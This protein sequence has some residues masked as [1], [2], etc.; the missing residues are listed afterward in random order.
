MM[1]ARLSKQPIQYPL[2]CTS[3]KGAHVVFADQYGRKDSLTP[4]MS[5][6]VVLVVLECLSCIVTMPVQREAAHNE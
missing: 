2:L 3:V 4:R 6:R 1:S 5:H